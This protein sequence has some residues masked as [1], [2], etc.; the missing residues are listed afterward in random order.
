MTYA[1]LADHF[2]VP[3]GTIRS[4]INRIRAKFTHAN[5]DRPTE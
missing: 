2:G 3:I 4:R 5:D 1:E